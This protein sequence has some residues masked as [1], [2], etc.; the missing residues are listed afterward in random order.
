MACPLQR[1]RFLRCRAHRDARW[2][3]PVLLSFLCTDASLKDQLLWQQTH[4]EDLGSHCDL[5]REALDVS[6]AQD[7]PEGGVNNRV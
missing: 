6:G 4:G 5:C 3:V 1:E 7:E 2:P